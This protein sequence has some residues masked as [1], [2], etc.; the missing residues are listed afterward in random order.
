VGGGGG[1]W[2]EGGGG[3]FTLSI[4]SSFLVRNGEPA[5]RVRGTT[6]S[7]SVLE[8]LGNIVAVGKELEV[9]AGVFGGCGKDDQQAKVGLGGPPVRLSRLTVGGTA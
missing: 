3:T 4:G 8:T 6:V 2:V 9:K 5:E 1:G 7:G